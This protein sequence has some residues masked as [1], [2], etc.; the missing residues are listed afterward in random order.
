MFAG[1][2]AAV[3]W[4]LILGRLA[5]TVAGYLWLTI[6]AAVVAWLCALVL[7]RRGDRGAAAGVAMATGA[8][9]AVAVG[10]VVYEWTT[11]GWPLW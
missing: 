10:V 7:M 4:L 5:T 8:G 3:A 1:A 6:I 9:V 2:G 11:A